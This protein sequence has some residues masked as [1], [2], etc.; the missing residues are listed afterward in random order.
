[1]YMHANNFDGTQSNL[2]DIHTCTDE[3]DYR[4]VQMHIFSWTE[5]LNQFIAKGKTIFLVKYSQSKHDEN[6]S[7][8][9]RMTI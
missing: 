4:N 3:N 6:S 7:M 1:M 8:I 2:T 5:R 9:I